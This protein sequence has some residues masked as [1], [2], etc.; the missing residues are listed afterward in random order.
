MKMPLMGLRITSRQVGQE[1]VKLI[2]D[3]G[4]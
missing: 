4:S 3:V 1:L 2:L